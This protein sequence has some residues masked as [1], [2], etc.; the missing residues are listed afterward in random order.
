M[1]DYSLCGLPNRLA[2]EGEELE[3]HKFSTGSMGLRAPVHIELKPVEEF[4][5][6]SPW[7]RVKHFFRSMALATEPRSAITETVVCMPPG[8]DLILKGIPSY[9]QRRYAVQE[10]EGVKFMQI[11][12]NV[13]SYRDAVQFENGRT[14][15][16]QELPEGMRIEVLSLARVFATSLPD[17]E[18]RRRATEML[19]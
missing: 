3:V 17:A 16:L 18:L 5:Y 13:N 12:A 10:D 19:T 8:A 2:M 7:D 14:V 11:S 1:C 4:V 15:G 9:L 6:K